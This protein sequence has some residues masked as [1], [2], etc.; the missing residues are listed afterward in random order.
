MS[1]RGIENTA[2]SLSYLER[3]QEATAFNLANANTDA[4]KAIRMAA[5]S[6]SEGSN[7]EAVPTLNLNQGTLSDTGQPLDLSLE[8][9]GFFVVRTEAGERLTRGGSFQIDA[10]GRL[11]DPRGAPVLAEEGD[12][13][14]LGSKVLVQSDGTIL[15]DGAA[16]GRLRIENVPDPSSLQRE[17]G[18]WFAPTSPPTPVAEGAAK[19]RQGAVE[20]ANI[21]PITSLVDLL[22]IQRAYSANMQALRAMDDVLGEANQVGRV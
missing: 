20:A 6:S 5:H 19:V 16:A 17:G 8:G 15:V 13:V 21:D 9:P 18:G 1:L 2:G 22:T 7:P 4:F 10:D 12:V 11:V 14:I 3:L